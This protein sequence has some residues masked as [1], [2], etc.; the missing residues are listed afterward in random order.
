MDTTQML[1]R[2]R[3]TALAGGQL[4]SRRF[5]KASGG[6]NDALSWNGHSKRP[7][8]QGYRGQVAL[9]ENRHTSFC[10]LREGGRA[11]VDSVGRSSN[12]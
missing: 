11:L 4:V 3:E 8:R 6:G 1:P 12:I 2:Q 9:S 7:R 10:L 5:G